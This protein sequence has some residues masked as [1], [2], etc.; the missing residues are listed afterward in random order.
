[1][2]D[3]IRHDFGYFC[4]RVRACA[5]HEQ[6]L[7]AARDV[8]GN[9]GNLGRRLALTEHD[10]RKPLAGFAVVVDPGEPQV[11]GGNEAEKCSRLGAGLGRGDEA[12]SHLVEQLEQAS[13]GKFLIRQGFS[14][15]SVEIDFLQ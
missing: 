7:A 5:R 15:D 13:P 14:F 8:R 3:G 12:V 4:P 2:E 1:M 10:L 9:G 11:G 6:G